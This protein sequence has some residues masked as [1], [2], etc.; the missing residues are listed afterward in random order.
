MW[1]ILYSVEVGREI[2]TA[3]KNHW[4]VR[5]NKLKTVR[6]EKWRFNDENSQ[7]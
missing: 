7:A 1:D 4:I 2:S 6:S 3:S 5:I